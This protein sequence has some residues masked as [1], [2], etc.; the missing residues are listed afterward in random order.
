MHE[1]GRQNLES[2][3]KENWLPQQLPPPCWILH[4][5]T[6]TSYISEENHLCD[7]PALQA[8]NRCLLLRLLH[9]SFIMVS[10]PWMDQQTPC[11]YHCPFLSPSNLLPWT[12]YPLPRQQ[13]QLHLVDL[14]QEHQLLHPGHCL[15]MEAPTKEMVSKEEVQRTKTLRPEE[16]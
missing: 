7:Y 11:P 2:F 9:L 10:T 3:K 6:M 8:K 15:L 5:R 14:H 4:Q 12:W 1:N 13:R 16:D